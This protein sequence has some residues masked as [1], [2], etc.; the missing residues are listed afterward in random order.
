MRAFF[1]LPF[2]QE[3]NSAYPCSSFYLFPS[4]LPPIVVSMVYR[5]LRS[6]K[7]KY[8]K[9]LRIFSLTLQ[10]YSPKAY[11]YVRKVFLNLLPHP[12]TLRK[13]CCSV[14][15]KPGFNT[16]VFETIQKLHTNEQPIICNLVFDEI[17]IRRGVRIRHGRSYSFVD[18]GFEDVELYDDDHTRD[19]TPPTATKALVFMLVA[20]NSNWKCPC[21]YVLIDTLSGDQRARLLKRCL[22]LSNDYN[23]KVHS[24]TFDG[25][26]INF[27]AVKHLGANMD[28]LSKK[29]KPFFLHPTT[30]EKVFVLPD[31]CHTLKNIRNAFEHYGMLFNKE[32]ATISWK[33]LERL[34]SIQE[35]EGSRIGNK[36]M[37]KHI[38]FK[39][40]IMNVKLA[41]QTLSRSVADSL[42]Y[43]KNSK[44]YG[45]EFC[46]VDATAEFCKM[47]NDSFDVLNC[48][49]RYS[50]RF[51]SH[52]VPIDVN[53]K[54]TL[55]SY[56]EE[57][58]T[59]LLALELENGRT[60]VRSGRRCGFI[61]MITSLS[62][63]LDLFD[64]LH[65]KYQL[66]YLLTYKLLQDHIENF[67][68]TIR[69]KGG[70][71]NNRDSFQFRCAYRRLLIHHHVTSSQ[72]ANGEVD[73]IPILTV[74]LSK[75]EE[76]DEEVLQNYDKFNF[77]NIK[78]I[79][80]EVVFDVVCYIGGCI[81]QKV[82][83]KKS[84]D[85]CPL[86]VKLIKE[87]TCVSQLIKIKDR[88]GLY[89]P[90]QTVIDICLRLEQFI[91]SNTCQLFDCNFVPNAV[92]EILNDGNL[93]F[94]DSGHNKD[95]TEA[96][97]V[98]ICNYYL[99]IR[100]YYESTILVEV[101]KY[102][103]RTLTKIVIFK[104]Q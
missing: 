7:A 25:D 3:R 70:F 98:L 18:L 99:K 17:T 13:W 54:E 1:A 60:V 50:R 16:E 10:F 92:D 68:S 24:V 38:K 94:P 53:T 46:H 76:F 79:T 82:S 27:S 74:T 66:K 88:G 97:T 45:Q 5:K 44:T 102:I 85:I 101:D 93:C 59:Y 29:Y 36:V 47:V 81:V 21:G 40:N 84:V 35:A 61:G 64:L 67:F 26:K 73:E 48:R 71:N 52:K 12:A 51:E 89:Q 39:E 78:E 103:R 65:E 20:V 57:I 30:K 28:I 63:V 32:A 37:K 42:L 104:N 55:R 4:K 96:L 34:H 6:Q 49:S 80:S 75:K 14:D 33:Y 8:E 91:K 56:V 15:G 100:L 9:E 41:T 2:H 62:N 11:D 19:G 58:K 87:D 23:I 43:L 95:R 90:T 31:R 83:E 69:I 22:A 77:E 86:C 72:Y